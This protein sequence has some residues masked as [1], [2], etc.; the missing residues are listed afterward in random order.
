MYLKQ[1]TTILLVILISSSLA[2]G[3]SFGPPY[4]LTGA[5]GESLC[6][7]CH[8]GNP[9][10]SGGGLLTISASASQYFR[11]DTIAIRIDLKRP[12]GLIWGFEATAIS[13][14]NARIGTILDTS[15]RTQLYFASQNGRQYAA[16]TTLG[17][18]AGTQD[19]SPGWGFLWVAPISAQGPVTF[20]AAGNAGNANGDNSG[21]YIYTTNFTIPQAPCCLGIVGNVDCD[22][23]ESVDIADLTRLVDNLFISFAPLCCGEEA[24]V[25]GLPGVDIGDLT[26]LVDHL[27]I[28]FQP[29][30]ACS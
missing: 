11:G 3:F 22:N 29:L 1:I 6:T 10:N 27:F 20:Y 25:D 30:P 23:A 2:I 7:V 19:S 9:V 26:R 18:F 28:S 21:D 12:G 17:S 13:D 15:D 24:N 16:H 5:P 8:S 4:P 14:T